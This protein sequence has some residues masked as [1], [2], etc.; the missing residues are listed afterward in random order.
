MR[1]AFIYDPNEMNPQE[2]IHNNALIAEGALWDIYDAL[3][4]KIGSGSAQAFQQV[5][6]LVV[7]AIQL[8]PKP[9]TAKRH[10]VNF[11][12]F[13]AALTQASQIL[14]FS[15][16]DQ[17]EIQNRL[18]ARGMVGGVTLDP[19]W[20]E[21]GPGLSDTQTPGLRILDNPLIL[22]G[23]LNRM[24][25]DSRVVTQ[26]GGPGMDEMAEPGEVI[27]LWFDL[28]N[29]TATTAGGVLLSV[30]SVDPRVTFLNDGYNAGF[31]DNAHTEVE[32]GKVNGTQIV[33]SLSSKNPA[34]RVPTGNAYFSSNPFFDEFWRNAIWIKVG[35]EIAHGTTVDF[36]L[37][38]T[39]SNGSP[40]QPSQIL[41]YQM[42]VK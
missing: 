17:I 36:E 23:W 16:G 29:V 2:E 15:S 11:R 30:R 31:I 22:K 38:L 26:G 33:Q 41:K 24:G 18:E 39:P 28:R 21:V 34:Y 8:L 40:T 25:A 42:V 19:V 10:P 27:A 13:G 9:T 12:S 5:A 6:R 20:A 32:Y 1:S 3:K 4:N 37:T 7:K 14:Q 35:A